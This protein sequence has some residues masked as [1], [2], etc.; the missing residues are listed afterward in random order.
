MHILHIGKGRIVRFTGRGDYLAVYI[1]KSDNLKQYI[2]KKVYVIVIGDENEGV[3]DN[4]N[5]SEEH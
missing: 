1:G 2:G 4:F 5:I 3:Q